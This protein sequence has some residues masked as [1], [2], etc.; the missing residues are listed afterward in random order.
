MNGN[1]VFYFNDS[2]EDTLNEARTRFKA[3]EDENK[4]LREQLDNFKKD[5]EIALLNEKISSVYSHSLLVLSDLELERKDN[6]IQHHWESC[7]ATN[8]LF[9]LYN[10]GIGTVINIEC[11]KCGEKVDITDT[12]CW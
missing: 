11:P 7:G 2:F 5:T 10:T 9:D 3:L 6:F 8:W 4:Q 12:S 1:M